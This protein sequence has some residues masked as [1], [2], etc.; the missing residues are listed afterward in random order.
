MVHRLLTRYLATSGS[1][2]TTSDLF[3]LWPYDGQW[4]LSQGTAASTSEPEDGGHANSGDFGLVTSLCS[5]LNAQKA[6]VGFW[7]YVLN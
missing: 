2:M 4:V 6:T 3:S 1:S 7:R 5:E